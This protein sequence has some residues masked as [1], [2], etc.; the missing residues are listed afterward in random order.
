M[1]T[2]E[3]LAAD[4]VRLGIESGDTIFVHSSFKSIG[5]VNGGATSVVGAMED[6]VG[7]EGLLLMPS[8][9]LLPK[10]GEARAQNWN[11][12]TTP[13]S[14]GWLTEFFRA[15]PGTVRSDHYSHSVAAR[16]TDAKAFVSDHLSLEGMES[17]WDRPPWGRTFG[18]QSPMLKASR[19]PHGKVLMLGTNYDT[20]TYRHV[21]ETMF[22]AWQKTIRHDEAF[23][24]L[25]GNDIFVFWDQL[26]RQKLGKIGDSDCR[27]FLIGEFLDSLLDAAKADPTRFF[28]CDQG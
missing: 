1:H 8:F 19:L 6:A 25:D 15:M 24:R 27:L 12:A 2:R 14:A 22:W 16:G 5:P 7:Q 23:A 28:K 9:N 10:G 3:S 18:T 26:H 13:S 20:L 11:R 21:I 4:A 17:P